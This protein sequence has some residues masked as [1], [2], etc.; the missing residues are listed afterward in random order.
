MGVG[1]GSILALRTVPPGEEAGCVSIKVTLKVIEYNLF[2]VVNEIVTTP[3]FPG[4]FVKTR[5]C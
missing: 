5:Q 1:A 3:T 2:M 4:S